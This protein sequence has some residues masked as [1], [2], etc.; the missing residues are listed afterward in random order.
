MGDKARLQGGGSGMLLKFWFHF[1]VSKM[2]LIPQGLL[3]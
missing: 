2:E 1:C 3:G